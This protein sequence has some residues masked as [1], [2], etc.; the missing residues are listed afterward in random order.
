MKEL[1]NDGGTTGDSRT[2]TIAFTMLLVVTVFFI[3]FS[4]NLPVSAHLVQPVRMV[5]DD[6]ATLAQS[7]RQ[8]TIWFE[9][10]LQTGRITVTMV[11]GRGK[12]VNIGDGGLDAGDPAHRSLAVE[13]PALAEGVYSVDWDVQAA[14][15]ES[16]HG[17][18]QFGVG[19][20]TVLSNSHA[21]PM[22]TNP[23]NTILTIYW[24][25]GMAAFCLLVG[26]ALFFMQVKPGRK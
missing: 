18:Y 10:T 5:P 6:G 14:D 20:V 17:S 8:V 2:A 13:L 1:H 16:A 12:M 21:P 23:A 25:A 4:V 22:G 15:G 3:L 24:L 19:D 9:A 11:D 26:G 7:P